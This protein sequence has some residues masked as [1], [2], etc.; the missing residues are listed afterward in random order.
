MSAK[1]NFYACARYGLNAS[2]TWYEGKSLL[3]RELI[4]THLLPVAFDGLANLGLDDASINTWLGI[5]RERAG[6]GQNGAHWQ[7]AWVARHGH[8]MNRLVNRYY[9]L[10]QQEEPVHT[11]PI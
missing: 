9:E 11:W 7:R 2:V 3:V 1:E 10:Q 4:L 8:D 6:T 5:I